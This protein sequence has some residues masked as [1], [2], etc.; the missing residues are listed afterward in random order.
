MLVL[1]AIV[2]AAALE[3]IL[4]RLEKFMPRLVAALATYLV[5]ALVVGTGVYLFLGPLVGQSHGLSGKLPVYFDQLLSGVNSAAAGIGIQL[6]PPDQV[7]AN[8]LKSAEG[9]LQQLVVQA[10]GY[11]QLVAGI[12]ADTALV[13]SEGFLRVN[14][15]K[16]VAP[17]EEKYFTFLH[18][19]DGSLTEDELTTWFTQHAVA[20]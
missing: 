16:I 12:A 3:P 7:R 1:L 19:A 11:I 20:L 4:S 6:P 8:L 10:I 5:A 13:V 2:V 15:V 14:G 18:L 17:P 9:Q